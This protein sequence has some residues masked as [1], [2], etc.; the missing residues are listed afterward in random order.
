MNTT[1]TNSQGSPTSGNAAADQHAAIGVGAAT[2]AGAHT[3]H[4]EAQ[5][6]PAAG[7]GL[8]IHWGIASVHGNADLSWAMMANTVYD[9]QARG[10][11]KLPPEDYWKLADRF[12]P[13]RWDP[14]RLLAAAARAGMT[15]AVLTAMHHDGYTLWPSDPR[16]SELGVHTHLGGRDL[17]APFV[18]ACRRHGLKVGL[19][20]SP[21]DWYA[22]RHH[23]SF[24]YGSEQVGRFPGRPHFDTRHQPIAT[25]R[26][27]SAQHLA[28]L[29]AAWLARVEEL[30]T[31]YGRIDLL[32][33][34][35]GTRDNAI[36]DR[37]RQLQPHLVIN[38]RSCDGDFDC[39]ECSLPTE[40]F[41]GWFETPHCWQHSDLVDPRTG[42]HVDFWGYLRDEQ[43][44]PTSWM[45]DTLTRLR[46]WGGNLLINVGP[47]PDG[48]MP[49]V[50]YARLNET[51]AWMAH[52]RE[53]V[54]GAGPGPYPEQS[55]VPVTTRPVARDSDGH[56]AGP[57]ATWYLHLRAGWRQTVRVTG[58]ARPARA[59][60][61]RNDA[62]VAFTWRDDTLTFDLP[63]DQRSGLVDV[64]ALR[65]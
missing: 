62:D 8:F 14:D 47:R 61:L 38:S 50:V 7:L 44:K 9:A 17:V 16:H 1:P 54:I 20:Y 30:L 27:R 60:L 26:P 59:W 13:E 32:W 40:K 12:T 5:W 6:F 53:S 4:P 19:Y 41:R 22:D 28:R 42:N 34:D 36:R 3:L 35:G 2:G 63:A 65:W 15:Y 51:A 58:I 43:Y 24:N 49:E 18:E 55:N 31:G 39:T 48:S 23:M 52:S 11:N 64:V 45:L 25:I 33:F 37:A 56:N 21:P 10:A 57:S 46:T 29:R